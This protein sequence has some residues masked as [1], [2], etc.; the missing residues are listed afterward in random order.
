MTCSDWFCPSCFPL[1]DDFC[2][3]TAL[4]RPNNLRR[5]LSD[6]P[7]ALCRSDLHLPHLW[8]LS[9]CIKGQS[10]ATKIHFIEFE[11]YVIVEFHRHTAICRTWNDA[12]DQPGVWSIGIRMVRVFLWYALKGDFDDPSYQSAFMLPKKFS[13]YIPSLIV[14]HAATTWWG[15]TIRA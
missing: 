12:D 14:Q 3:C 2:K 6:Y 15:C 7:I 11:G 9:L 1:D 10:E 8:L 5:P 4:A 13:V